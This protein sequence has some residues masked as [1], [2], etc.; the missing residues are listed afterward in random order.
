MAAI[1]TIYALSRPQ[2]FIRLNDLETGCADLKFNIISETATASFG[3]AFSIIP[4]GTF[5]FMT[6]DI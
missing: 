6:H 3:Q 1:L 4:S 5:Y 2:E